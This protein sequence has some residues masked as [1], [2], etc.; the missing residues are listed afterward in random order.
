M[1][2]Q[3][4][5][6]PFALKFVD[7]EDSDPQ[8]KPIQKKTQESGMRK[9][10]LPEPRQK[11]EPESASPNS[12]GRS[13][14]YVRWGLLS[15]KSEIVLY[16]IKQALYRQSI[17][18]LA[19]IL[20][21]LLILIVHAKFVILVHILHLVRP[22]LA[23]RLIMILPRSHNFYEQLPDDLGKIGDDFQG[24]AYDELRKSSGIAAQYLSVSAVAGLFDI[25]A[26]LI[27]YGKFDN[28]D[29]MAAT[30]FVLAFLFVCTDFFLP[31]WYLTLQ[32]TF[33]EDIWFD[34]V[35]IARGSL[36]KMKFF[37]VTTVRRTT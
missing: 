2:G 7:Q 20:L 24:K 31:L 8:E 27:G 29:S 14:T 18:E 17:I 19:L 33:P 22:Y 12:S 34:L 16:D 32:F 35:T 5:E 25:I 28:H 37:V 4:K 1:A 21:G 3:V 30:Y 23:Y 9:N 15:A 26:L 13:K 6:D 36:E 10:I 11:S